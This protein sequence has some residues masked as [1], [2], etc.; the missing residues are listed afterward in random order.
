MR[1]ITA[2]VGVISHS[3][4]GIRAG[5]GGCFDSGSLSI[6]VDGPMN[7]AESSDMRQT[8]RDRE[9]MKQKKHAVTW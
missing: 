7:T 2:E 4:R 3:N 9:E 1:E 8:S 6:H 5:L